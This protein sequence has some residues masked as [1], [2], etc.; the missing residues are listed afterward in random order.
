M[1]TTT[2]D[3]REI[4]QSNHQPAGSVSGRA[5]DV[6]VND[7]RTSAPH[8]AAV[9]YTR[10]CSRICSYFTTWKSVHAGAIS[11]SKKSHL[12]FKNMANGNGYSIDCTD[13]QCKCRRE[14]SLWNISHLWVHKEQKNLFKNTLLTHRYEA[15]CKKKSSMGEYTSINL[16]KIFL[17][18]HFWH[19]GPK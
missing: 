13:T 18:I 10:K 19:I 11:L 17:K 8:V 5:L 4:H 1:E 7:E 16:K 15:R 12:K 9:F 3:G 2:G 6:G 14:I